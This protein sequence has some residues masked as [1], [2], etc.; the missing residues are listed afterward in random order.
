[1]LVVSMLPSKERKKQKANRMKL[2]DGNEVDRR[3]IAEVFET[4]RSGNGFS[5]ILVEENQKRK[6]KGCVSPELGA[7]CTLRVDLADN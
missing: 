4:G 2:Q 1:M 6:K 7:C 3:E 5:C